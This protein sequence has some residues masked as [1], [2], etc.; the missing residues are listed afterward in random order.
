MLLTGK[1][2]LLIRNDVF[3]D[4]SSPVMK[5]FTTDLEKC[6]EVLANGGVILYPTDT[7]W[8]LGCDATNEAAVE[9]LIRIKGKQ[10][11]KGLIVLLA[12]ER[13]VLK[14]VANPDL[15]VFNYLSTAAKPTTV[16]YEDGLAVAGNVLNFDGSI[17]IRL[18]NDE[19]CRHIVKQFRKP[20]VSTSA[21]FHGE[22]SPDNFFS[23]NRRLIKAVDYVVKYRSNEAETCA[24]SSLIKWNRD[25]SNTV[26]RP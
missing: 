19:F 21:N 22:P 6:L 18:V 8:G 3:A 11:Q 16:I 24:A 4:L 17:A 26:L 9:K 25:G 15:A 7:V 5:D 20:V 23:I 2:L 1:D 10:Q 12:S 14:H 13:D